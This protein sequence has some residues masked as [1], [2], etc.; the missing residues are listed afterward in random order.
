MKQKREKHIYRQLF[1]SF[2]KI[3]AFTFGG[4]Y[5]M[6]PLIHTEA[7]ERRNW[8]TDE[9]ILDIIA[10]AESTPG[11]MAVNSATFVG[12][13]VG[14]ILGSALA[15]A[16]VVLPSLAVISV[17]FFFIGAIRDNPWV[18]R[19]FLGVR[20]GVLGLLA[21]TAIKMIQSGW[22]GLFALLI[23]L[24]TLFLAAFTAIDIVW[25]LLAAAAAGICRGCFKAP[26]KEGGG[27]K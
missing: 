7:V 1:W 16:G 25:I 3:G 10:I 18:A 26:A 22:K 5:A 6:I 19:A 27:E 13:R 21:G 23:G 15:T 2:L 14:G 17:L 9:D 12:Y 20:A 24:I 8:I 4:G 11:T